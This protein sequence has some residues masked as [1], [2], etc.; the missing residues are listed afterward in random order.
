MLNIPEC[1]DVNMGFARRI[2][3]LILLICFIWV[4]L[5][6][7]PPLFADLGGAFETISDYM[8]L[9]YSPICHQEEVRSFFIAGNPLGVCSRCTMIYL[10]FAFGALI[11]PLF[12]KVSNVNPPSLWLLFIPLAM[13]GADVL[14][15]RTGVVSNTFLTRS[16]TGFLTGA[17][18]AFFIIPGFIRFFYEI[19]AYFRHKERVRQ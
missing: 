10:G 2:Y 18:L 13:I 4:A 6:I 7:L 1:P 11:Y 15:D 14:L 12:R 3:R 9:A 8:Y 17:S 5:I 19:T 16:F